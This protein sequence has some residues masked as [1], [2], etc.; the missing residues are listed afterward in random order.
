MIPRP[1]RST[2]TYTLFPYTTL[3]RSDDA[4][5]EIWAFTREAGIDQI[6]AF[7]GRAP[8]LRGLDHKA[9]PGEFLLQK[10]V[11]EIAGDSQRPVGIGLDEAL[12]QRLR[13]P[14]LPYREVG[15]GDLGKAVPR[16]PCSRTDQAATLQAVGDDLR[17][18]PP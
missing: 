2:L 8:P 7:M 17:Y 10:H 18:P 5:V 13:R 3:F 11:I 4:A 16:Q 1:P 9:L 12:H 6:G 14:L 15:S